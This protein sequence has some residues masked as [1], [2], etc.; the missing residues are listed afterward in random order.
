VAEELSQPGEVIDTRERIGE[1]FMGVYVNNVFETEATHTN[2]GDTKFL[3]VAKGEPHITVR[4][5]GPE[6]NIPIHSHPVNEMFYVIEG[7]MVIGDTV[8]KAGDMV[9]IEKGTPYGPTTAPK[10][11][12]ALRYAEA[13]Q[14][15]DV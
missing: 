11:V 5:W 3:H 1:V 6:T 15:R 13:G 4:I 9:Y 2:H 12:T 8:Y 7:E 14:D 10:G